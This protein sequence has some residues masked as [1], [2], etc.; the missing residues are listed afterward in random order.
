MVQRVYPKREGEE[1]VEG[2]FD[3]GYDQS[4]TPQRRKNNRGINDEED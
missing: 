3:G 4:G 1:Y 2:G